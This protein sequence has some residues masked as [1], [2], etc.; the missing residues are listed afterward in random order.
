[1]LFLGLSGVSDKLYAGAPGASGRGNSTPTIIA[2]AN[3]VGARTCEYVGAKEA[4]K[5][6]NNNIFDNGTSQGAAS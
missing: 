4:F 1:V 2:N 6:L 3:K 5:H